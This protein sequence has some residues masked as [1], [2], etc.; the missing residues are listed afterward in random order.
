LISRKYFPNPIEEDVIYRYTDNYGE[1]PNS[2]DET[3][4]GDD[5]YGFIVLEGDE[6]ALNGEFASNFVFT[7]SD[8]G[9]EILL[10]NV[11]H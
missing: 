2:P 8:D 1:D 9:S 10:E 7:R 5:L 11:S 3:D 6:G 4:V